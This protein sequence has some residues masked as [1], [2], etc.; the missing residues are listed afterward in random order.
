MSENRPFVIAREA[1]CF[2]SAQ[3]T[4]ASD[5]VSCAEIAVGRPARA[6]ANIMQCLIVSRPVG[7]LSGVAMQL[8]GWC[9][10]SEVRIIARHTR[11]RTSESRG[12]W[13]SMILVRFLD[14]KF[15]HERA[16]LMIGTQIHRTSEFNGEQ[17]YFATAESR[18]L[19]PPSV[20]RP[21]G[22]S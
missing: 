11:L 9:P 10:D 16:A 20:R 17:R 2:S 15:L 14:L 18:M 6:K 12:H 13:Q 4:G 21:A 1:I 5:D 8:S 7:R 22:H 19:R 3:Y